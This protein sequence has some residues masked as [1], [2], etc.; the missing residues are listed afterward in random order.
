MLNRSGPPRRL[1]QS[2]YNQRLGA[3]GRS[4]SRPEARPVVPVAAVAAV[5]PVAAVAV[6][7]VPVVVATPIAT[8]VETVVEPIETVVEPIAT[9]VEPVKKAVRRLRSESAANNCVVISDKDI[10][11]LLDSI[12]SKL[13]KVIT[14]LNS[15]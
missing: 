9:V 1:N 10:V 8:V 5:V 3:L 2:R 12:E 13:D 7:P 11:S 6:A 15:K 14:S 4:Q